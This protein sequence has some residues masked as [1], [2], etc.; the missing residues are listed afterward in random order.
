MASVDVSQLSK[1]E[2]DELTC[3]Y[4]ALL[5]HDDGLEITGEKLAKVIKASGNEVEA[6]WPAL[7][8]KALKGQ[9]IED[10]LSNLASAPSAGGAGPAVTVQET[11]AVAAKPKEEEKKKEEEADVDMGGLFGDDY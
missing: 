1:Q 3:A 5:L 11:T 7:F 4:A 9:N 8:A 2:H 6:Y 10:L